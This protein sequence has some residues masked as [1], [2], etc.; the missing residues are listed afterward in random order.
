MNDN[1][2]RPPEGTK[3]L[4]N[5]VDMRTRKNRA[6]GSR[7]TV[8]Y[9]FDLFV[10]LYGRV[11]TSL[12]STPEEENMRRDGWL[13]ILSQ[14]NI[15]EI[16]KAVKALKSGKLPQ[17]SEFPPKPLQFL[18]LCKDPFPSELACY[19]AAMRL[20][21]DFHPIVY[22]CAKACDIFWLRHQASEKAGY[23]RFRENYE[24]YKKLYIRG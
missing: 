2:V 13:D 18:T 5:I 19:E 4:G 3:S 17:Y 8:T 10:F 14:M 12:A 24:Y 11:W 15:L 23:Q 21:W 6:H 9:L 20:Q 16:E 1:P 7:K 22:P